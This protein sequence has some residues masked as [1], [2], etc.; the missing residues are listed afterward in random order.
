MVPA[1]DAVLDQPIAGLR[2]LLLPLFGLGEIARVSDDGGAGE[3]VG[4][5]DLVRQSLDCL[6]QGKVIDAAQTNSNLTTWPEDLSVWQSACWPEWEL[7][8]RKMSE[9]VFSLSLIVA[10]SRSRSSQ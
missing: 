8:R 4:Q 7:S 10:M 3:A 2:D 9:A 6:P 1:D 5:L